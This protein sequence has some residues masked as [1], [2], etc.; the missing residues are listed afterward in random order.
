MH[1]PGDGFAVAIKEFAPHPA[2]L[3]DS[4]PGVGSM[5]AAPINAQS[6]FTN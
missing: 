6:W 4:R 5:T 3:S 2:N 1:L